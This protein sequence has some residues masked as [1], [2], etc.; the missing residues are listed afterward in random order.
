[1]LAAGGASQKPSVP[2]CGQGSQE[3][4]RKD[5]VKENATTLNLKMENLFSNRKEIERRVGW[6][7]TWGRP[8]KSGGRGNH[9]QNIACGKTFS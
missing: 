7:R 3:E 4:A 9:D 5:D 8:G 1:M 2:L 6:I